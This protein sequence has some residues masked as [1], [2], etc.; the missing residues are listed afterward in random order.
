MKIGLRKTGWLAATLVAGWTVAGTEHAA[1]PAFERFKALAGE[2]VAAEDGEMVKKGQLV[3]RYR[4]TAGGTAVVEELFPG[5]HHA[6]DTVYYMDGKELVLTHYCMNGNQPRMRAKGGSSS[7]V[8]FAFDG[9]SNIDPKHTA[10]MHQATFDFVGPDELR[11]T[12]TEYEHGKAAMTVR[13][14]TVRKTD[15][16]H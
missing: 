14:H 3:A 4:V 15:A 2:W 1:S 12:W 8:E 9:G 11:A 5:Q 7:T 16:A 13:M 10:H 6:M